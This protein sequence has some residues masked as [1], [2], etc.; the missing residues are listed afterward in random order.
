MALLCVNCAL[1][2]MLENRPPPRFDESPE[3]HLRRVHP[4]PHVARQERIDMERELL[5]RLDDQSN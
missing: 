3:E 5:R 1:Q 4:D 2:A